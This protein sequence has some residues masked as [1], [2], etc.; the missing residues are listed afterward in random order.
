[1]AFDL[2]Y[3]YIQCDHRYL[4]D[5]VQYA[6]FVNKIIIDR[7]AI[8]GNIY[9]NEVTMGD[10]LL[11]NRPNVSIYSRIELDNDGSWIGIFPLKYEFGHS[12]SVFRKLPTAY[13]REPI[14]QKTYFSKKEIVRYGMGYRYKQF[15]NENNKYITYAG[16]FWRISDIPKI[17]WIIEP[18]YQDNKYLYHQL[19]IYNYNPNYNYIVDYN[20]TPNSC[21]HCKGFMFKNDLKLN[22]LGKLDIVVN[23]PKLVQQI[24]KAILTPKGKNIYYLN[25]GTFITQLI[26]EKNIGLSFLIRSEIR[27]QLTRIK[28][29][30]MQILSNY[31]DFYTP[32]EILYDLLGMEILKSQSKEVSIKLTLQTGAL[33]K[34]TT[35][36]IHL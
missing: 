25:Y 8:L 12:A 26:G 36:I 17:N 20:T 2:K 29:I 33:E 5:I 19:K 13:L 9:M 24:M 16:Y 10:Y 23:T 11:T 18:V 21:P 27:E 32:Y 4:D 14:S 3:T 1:M 22:N 35:Q 6:N 15:N 7:A 30:H 34:I 28:S 31:K